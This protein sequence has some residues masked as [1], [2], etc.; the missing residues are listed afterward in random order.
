MCI[1]EAIRWPDG[2]CEEVLAVFRRSPLEAC[3]KH[4]DIHGASDIVSAMGGK[5]DLLATG[6]CG[7]GTSA[8]GIA[9]TTGNRVEQRKADMSVD[10]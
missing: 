10:P 2:A 1:Q 8:L 7:E 9:H 5:E 3:C 6:D 4:M